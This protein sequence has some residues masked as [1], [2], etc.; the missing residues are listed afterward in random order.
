MIS[1]LLE[2]NTLITKFNRRI[3]RK[4]QNWSI[5]LTNIHAKI[6][7]KILVNIINHSIQNIPSSFQLL[8]R[9]KSCQLWFQLQAVRRLE[10]VTPIITRRKSWT[11]WKSKT[12]LGSIR[13]WRL[14]DKLPPQ[15]LG[16][17]TSRKI[18][19]LRLA[20][21]QQKFLEP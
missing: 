9:I 15:N 7:N 1:Y 21:L 12:L 6:P 10:D 18:W 2:V 16:G 11:K 13:Q 4:D 20:L 3:I 8:S 17:G 19:E 5:L 14:W